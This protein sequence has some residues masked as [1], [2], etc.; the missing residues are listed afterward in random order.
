MHCPR[1]S[2]RSLVSATGITAEAENETASAA[3]V[4]SRI[5]FM[6]I[7]IFCGRGW[8]AALSVKRAS[9]SRRCPDDFVASRHCR[10]YWTEGRQ[11]MGGRLRAASYLC[12]EH[13]RK[14]G[15][16]SPLPS[17]MTAK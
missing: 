8:Q 13:V 14:L 11:G 17:L 10:E 12:A 15:G 3:S 2:G 5:R 16:E 6:A 4:P 7:T 1:D 9:T